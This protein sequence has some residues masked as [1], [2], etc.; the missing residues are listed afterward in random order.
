MYLNVSNNGKLY[1]EFSD[2]DI[3]IAIKEDDTNVEKHIA[4][5]TLSTNLQGMSI[6]L[7]G[8]KLEQSL[9]ALDGKD[10]TIQIPVSEDLNLINLYNEGDVNKAH[11][12]ISRFRD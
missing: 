5:K 1:M 4:Y 9:K 3:T 6:S 11:V 7:P 8:F 2:T 10:V 12:I